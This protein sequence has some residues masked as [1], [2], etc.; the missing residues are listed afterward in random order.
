MTNEEIVLTVRS[1][2]ERRTELLGQL[3][4]QNL[5]MIRRFL[6]PYSY[7]SSMDDLL[8]SAFLA[9]VAAADAYPENADFE[10]ISGLRFYVQNEAR[11][12]L[13]DTGNFS[14]AGSRK[15]EKVP[16]SSLDAPL[17]SSLDDS[18]EELTLVDTLESPSD[19]E[20]AAT[21]ET[22]DAQA[23]GELESLVD[24]HTT[25]RQAATIKS[26]YFDGRTL[27]QEAEVQGVSIQ[28]I[29]S[30]RDGGIWKMKH[31]PAIHELEELHSEY[32]D[33][34]TS[35][36]AGV[37]VGYFNRSWESATERAGMRLA[38]LD[39]HSGESQ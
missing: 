37:G 27:K 26:L 21:A 31:S 19:T 5:P 25:P 18:D 17:R 24:A 20:S 23:H 7:Y 14:D 13:V 6:K 10:F 38:N 39:Y 3:Y 1:C 33:A 15:I 35:G 29:R 16:M 30:T 22:F 32:A 36:Y 4:A 2:P 34:V 8:Q 9:T 12:L 28:A 11:K